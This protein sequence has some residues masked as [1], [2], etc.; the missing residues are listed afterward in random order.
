[1]KHNG[2]A[3][4]ILILV[5]CIVIASWQQIKDLRDGDWNYYVA[6]C[7]EFPQDHPL[8]FVMLHLVNLVIG[9]PELTVTV[10]VISAFSLTYFLVFELVKQLTNK[11]T[12]SFLTVIFLMSC[13]VPNGM[14]RWGTPL[15]NTYGLA[16]FFATLILLLQYEKSKSKTV[17]V[18]LTIM[19]FLTVIT[20]IVGTFFLL[21]TLF[22]YMIHKVLTRKKRAKH[23]LLLLLSLASFTALLTLFV[24]SF[25]RNQKVF[26]VLIILNANLFS[27]ITVNIANIFKGPEFWSLWLIYILSLT[28]IFLN[29]RNTKKINPIALGLL[30]CTGILLHLAPNADYFQRFF[31]NIPIILSPI[32]G[33]TLD[34]TVQYF[35]TVKK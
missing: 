28:L 33:V 21:I 7:T 17:L 4:K 9:N 23:S 30:V 3:I 31:M 2:L 19:S 29:F 35:Q 5:L 15:K 18:G 16:F 34:L 27:I 12:I 24:S 20:H 1:M 6:G 8:V 26:S 11:F 10:L 32:V 13:C 14:P 25:R 22:I